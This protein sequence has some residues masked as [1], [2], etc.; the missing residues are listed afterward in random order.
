MK[1]PNFL[2]LITATLTEITSYLPREKDDMKHYYNCIIQ[3]KPGI[4][5][6]WQV[7]GRSETSFDERLSLDYTYNQS[8]GMKCDTKILIQTAFKVFKR[9]GAR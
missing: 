3:S 4:T 6:L 8:K 5:G 9:E 7:S 1:F 2:A